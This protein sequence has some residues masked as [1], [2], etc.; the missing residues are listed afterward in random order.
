M[1]DISLSSLTATD[2]GMNLDNIGEM[3]AGGAYSMMGGASSNMPYDFA[4]ETQDTASRSM[5][6]AYLFLSLIILVV[7]NYQAFSSLKK[8]NEEDGKKQGSATYAIK[9]TLAVLAAILWLVA[10]Y[11]GFSEKAGTDFWAKLLIMVTGFFQLSLLMYSRAGTDLDNAKAF[12]YNCSIF[13]ILLQVGFGVMSI[14]T[15]NNQITSGAFKGTMVSR[16]AQGMNRMY[17]SSTQGMNRMYDNSVGATSRAWNDNVEGQKEASRVVAQRREA[18]RA[19]V[20]G[21]AQSGGNYGLI[22]RN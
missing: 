11:C 19:P 5:F 16:G 18:R 20:A 17:D 1:S 12:G 3:I 21:Q 7:V 6:Y 9:V 4:Q 22:S 15:M 10:L 8:E 2:H 14:P 13:L